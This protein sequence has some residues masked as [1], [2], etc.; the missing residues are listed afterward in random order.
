M[1]TNSNNNNNSPPKSALD[2]SAEIHDSS[3]PN[4]RYRGNSPSIAG[5]VAPPP[6]SSH[7]HAAQ[8]SVAQVN[9]PIS[10]YVNSL[11]N[12]SFTGSNNNPAAAAA[13]GL[14]PVIP[15]HLQPYLPGVA[16]AAAAAAGD[17][18]AYKAVMS[19]PL[20][21]ASGA[22]VAKR[23]ASASPGA[24]SSGSGGGGG[25]EC[26]TDG[27]DVKT[28]F[29]SGLPIDTKHRELYLLFRFVKDCSFIIW[30]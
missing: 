19:A 9:N 12:N 21:A 25:A 1:N 10:T 16:A 6:H 20:D 8:L 18:A 13:A 3:P 11:Q 29:V 15:S 22:M 4:K 23:E 24:A 26:G 7:I 14:L 17:A 27:T 30:R 5:A 28:L 2:P